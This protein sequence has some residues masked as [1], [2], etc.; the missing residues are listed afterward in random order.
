MRCGLRLQKNEITKILDHLRHLQW[1]NVRQHTIF[2]EKHNEEEY[3]KN[4][5]YQITMYETLEKSND[6]D[7]VDI[8]NRRIRYLL[9]RIIEKMQ[10][11]LRMSKYINIQL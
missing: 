9:T 5:K 4:T 1:T 2:N 10:I 7:D 11:I 3:I 8:D 6:I